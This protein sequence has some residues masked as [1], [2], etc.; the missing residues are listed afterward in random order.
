[1]IDQLSGK[2]LLILGASVEE[3]SLVE[4]AKEFGI[5]T[6]VTDYYLDHAVSPAKDVADEAW[7]VSWSDL[8]MLEKLCRERH[9]DGITAGYSE[10]RVESLIKLCQRLGLPC[11]PCDLENAM[12]HLEK[13]A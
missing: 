12:I 10:F 4:R 3:V 6:I 7:D 1:M 9:V 2:T 13:E 5:R 11:V 8:D